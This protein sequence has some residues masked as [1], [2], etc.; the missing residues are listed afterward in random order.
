MRR[1][2]RRRRW[3]KRSDRFTTEAQ[4]TQ[5]LLCDLCASVVNHFFSTIASNRRFFC[6]PS[7]ESFDATGFVFPQPFVIIFVPSRCSFVVSHCLTDSARRSDNARL[8]LSLPT[9]SV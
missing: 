4:S 7:A 2:T 6:L 1:Q 9:E 3:R 8:Y 5:R